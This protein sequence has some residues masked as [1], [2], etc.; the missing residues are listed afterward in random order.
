MYQNCLDC[1]TFPDIWKKSSICLVH[2]TND[3]QIINNCRPVSL[4]PVFG[5]IF[6]NL[7]FKSLFECLDEHKLVSEHQSGLR[8]NDSCTNQ[9]LSIVL[10]IY[11][12]FDAGPTPEV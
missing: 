10:D 4:L 6:E 12:A 9:L 3:K 1:S 2:K 5:K 7:I 8:P 11:T